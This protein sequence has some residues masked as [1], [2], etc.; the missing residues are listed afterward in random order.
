MYLL[1]GLPKP[2]TEDTVDAEE[3][4][5]DDSPS[6]DSGYDPSDKELE[7]LQTLT[8]IVL[9]CPNVKKGALKEF[10]KKNNILGCRV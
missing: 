8:A 7:L 6:G 10:E 5:E 3:G 9:D 1:C 4:E 2:V